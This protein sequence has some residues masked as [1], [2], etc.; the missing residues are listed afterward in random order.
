MEQLLESII[1]ETVS[2][3]PAVNSKAKAALEFMESYSKAPASDYRNQVLGV[4]TAALES[5]NN[6]LSHQTV[7]I[8]HKIGKD[9][10]FH[11]TELEEDQSM[12][13]SQQVMSSV[14]SSLVTVSADLQT[15]YLQALLTLSYHHCWI[16]SGQICVEVVTM[17]QEILTAASS[18]TTRTAAQNVA[19]NNLSCLARWLCKNDT[20]RGVEDVIPVL[21]FLCT[22]IEEC[23]SS[24][25]DKSNKKSRQEKEMLLCCLD[26]TVKA[27]STK[28]TQS[29]NFCTFLW[30]S[31]CPSLIKL[32]V[33]GSGHS[34]VCS[35]T[36]LIGHM[37][38]HRPVLEATFHKMLVQTPPEKR[39]DALKAVS[40]LLA[41]PEGLL[42]LTWLH[43][44]EENEEKFNTWNDMAILI[45]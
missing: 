10:R 4:V 39:V 41:E 3:Y 20:E 44:S 5:G 28:V 45:M 18:A 13:L 31:L 40:K 36:S 6:K 42:H 35:L 15:D 30:R 43:E 7:I 12:W 29:T 24:S 11:S 26:T 22:N 33:R 38:S 14:S 16:V 9:D 8:I 34:V 1:K 37:E 32:L 21:Q 27:L 17:C 25:S 23:F 19:A 2:K